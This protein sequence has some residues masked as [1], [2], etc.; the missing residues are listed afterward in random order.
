MVKTTK[1]L[2]KISDQPL[3]NS[4]KKIKKEKSNINFFGQVIFRQAFWQ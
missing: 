1:K 4:F 3:I 2:F